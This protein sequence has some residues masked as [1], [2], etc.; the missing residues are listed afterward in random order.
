[1]LRCDKGLQGLEVRGR[2][3]LSALDGRRYWYPWQPIR[4]VVGARCDQRKRRPCGKWGISSLGRPE[5]GPNRRGRAGLG[6]G[7]GAFQVP[8]TCE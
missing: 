6:T 1:M 2:C 8:R 5:W 4:C 3:R 7:S